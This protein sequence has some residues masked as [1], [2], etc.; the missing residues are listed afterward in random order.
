[1]NHHVKLYVHIE[2]DMFRANV[3]PASRRNSPITR[4]PVL[5]ARQRDMW[6]ILTDG[7]PVTGCVVEYAKDSPRTSDALVEEMYQRLTKSGWGKVDTFRCLEMDG[8]WRVIVTIKR[9]EN[10]KI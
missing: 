1:M 6:K 10:T 8:C 3:F 4:P 7:A 2:N 9:K 5:T